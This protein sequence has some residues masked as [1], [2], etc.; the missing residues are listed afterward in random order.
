MYLAYFHGERILFS[1]LIHG[2]LVVL[3]SVALL[4][5]LLKYKSKFGALVVL[6]YAGLVVASVLIYQLLGNLL[7]ESIATMLTL[8]WSLL[9]PCYGLDSSCS[10]SLGVALI[11]A[12]LNAAIIYLLIAITSRRKYEVKP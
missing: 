4:Y 1:F 12:E 7:F 6:G 5:G 8:P 10:L 3:S 11:C 2:F 9:L